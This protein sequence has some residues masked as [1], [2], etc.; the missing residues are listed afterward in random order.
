MARYDYTKMAQSD[1]EAIPLHPS[2]RCVRAADM[3]AN[4]FLAPQINQVAAA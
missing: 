2:V 4:R 1:Y 3:L